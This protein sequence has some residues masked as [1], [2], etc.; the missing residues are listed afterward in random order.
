MDIKALMENVEELID[1]DATVSN[2]SELASLYIVLDHFQ[3]EKLEVAIK[4]A[5]DI[6]PAYTYYAEA[7]RNYQTGTGTEDKVFH[8]FSILCQEIEEFL[9]I[10]Y[11]G[12]IS[13]KEKRLF[14]KILENLSEMAQT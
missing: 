1:S 3:K 13:Y 4:E 8:T 6:L 9:R 2:V 7:K 11:V 5:H 10:I 12:T 14:Q